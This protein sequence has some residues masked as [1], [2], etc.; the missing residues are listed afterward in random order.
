[1]LN[2]KRSDDLLDREFVIVEQL[3]NGSWEKIDSR[4]QPT[5]IALGKVLNTT[6]L[7]K[8]DYTYGVLESGTLNTAK[9]NGNIQSQ[10]ITVPTVG[11]S[12]A[13]TAV[14]TYNYDSL[15]RIDD[16]TEKIGSTE[17]WKQDYTFDRYG[18]RNFVEANTT[19]IPRNCQDNQSPPNPAIC[20]EDRKIMNPSVNASNNPP[21]RRG[22]LPIR[23]CRKYGA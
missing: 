14:Q 4:L 2:E 21:E 20:D 17:T 12:N 9:N 23:C 1:M 18:N 11:S 7:L 16:A 3:W 19:T 13:F 15:N 6:D 5:Q 22:R 8:L 10:T